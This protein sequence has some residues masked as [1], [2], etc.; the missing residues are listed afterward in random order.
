MHS[1]GFSPDTGNPTLFKEKI[2][3][4]AKV[5]VICAKVCVICAKVCV[6]C[7]KVCAKGRVID[8]QQSKGYFVM[9]V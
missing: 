2:E 3:F 8:A 6:I 4:S 1:L 7:A 9:Y 5:C